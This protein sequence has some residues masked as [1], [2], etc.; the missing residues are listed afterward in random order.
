MLRK[1][2]KDIAIAFGLIGI[3]FLILFIAMS[4]FN[5]PTYAW[6]ILRYGRSDIRDYDIFPERAI[7]NGPTVSVIERG[8]AIHFP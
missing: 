1:V 7:L 3:F 8:K 6:R 5:S 2:A 4:I